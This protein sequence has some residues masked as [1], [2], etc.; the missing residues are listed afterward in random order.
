MSNP[1]AKPNTSATAARDSG[2]GGGSNKATDGSAAAL[3]P[4]EKVKLTIFMMA[5]MLM[6][7]KTNGQIISHWRGQGKMTARRRATKARGEHSRA[8]T[9]SH[10]RGL[11]APNRGLVAHRKDSQ[12]PTAYSY[13]SPMLIHTT[14]Q[15][16]KC[17][18]HE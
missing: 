13:H 3:S 15:Y 16:D 10:N 8:A 18:T 12:Y 5:A 7:W 1:I 14:Y 6:E 17:T 2:L 11:V 9:P 4:G